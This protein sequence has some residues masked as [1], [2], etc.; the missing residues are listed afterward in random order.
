MFRRS[1]VFILLPILLLARS[2]AIGHAHGMG[3]DLA[4]PRPHVHVGGFSHHSG[5]E[6]DEPEVHHGGHHHS[7]HHDHDGHHH[8]DAH[9]ED[10]D[11]DALPPAEPLPQHDDDAI[12]IDI[13]DAVAENARIRFH[14]SD[15]AL[16]WLMPAIASFSDALGADSHS[17]VCRGHPPPG[18]GRCPL[19][20]LR[21][22]LVI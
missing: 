6:G 10:G 9:H 14:V 16:P 22:V 21:L 8:H 15:D 5:H 12:E 18:N 4:S 13:D 19:H 3:S 7:H 1:V 2:V 17:P 11:S 20:L